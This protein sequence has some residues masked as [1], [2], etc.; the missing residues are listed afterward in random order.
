[1]QDYLGHRDPKHTAHYTR[2]AGHRFEGLWRY[3]HA[4]GAWWRLTPFPPGFRRYRVR[5]RAAGL[6]RTTAG[7]SLATPLARPRAWPHPD[8]T[9]SRVC[10]AEPKSFRTGPK[11]SRDLAPGFAQRKK[12]IARTASV[13][14]SWA[15]H[16]LLGPFHSSCAAVPRSNRR[17]QRFMLFRRQ[18]S[19]SGGRL[20]RWPG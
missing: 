11:T 15:Q 6:S 12:E 5:Q 13:A 8:R 9:A 2:V 20:S 17:R 19:R 3:R 16:S 18:R 1:M 10:L 4:G 7:R 14:I